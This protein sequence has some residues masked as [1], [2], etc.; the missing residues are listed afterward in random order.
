M[1]G[2]VATVVL[3]GFPAALS[4]ERTTAG[5]W[6]PSFANAKNHSRVSFVSSRSDQ[7]LLLSRRKERHLPVL[8][9]VALV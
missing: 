8:I 2:Q 3:P 5:D 7:G 1:P 6:L 4:T 9:R